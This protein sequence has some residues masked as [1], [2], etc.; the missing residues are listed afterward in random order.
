MDESCQ[1]VRKTTEIDGTLRLDSF[2]DDRKLPRHLGPE[3]TYTKY[4]D[5]C[6][7][8]GC[9]NHCYPDKPYCN[10]RKHYPK[11]TTSFP[12]LMYIRLLHQA[13]L[14]R[15]TRWRPEIWK[16]LLGSSVLF[17]S[18]FPLPLFLIFLSNSSS[19]QF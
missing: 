8:A 11:I 6:R 5:E 14:Q 10:A 17:P 18:P 12:D 16:F 13:R 2:C 19:S 4:I 9:T 15:S 7:A 3:V 1:N